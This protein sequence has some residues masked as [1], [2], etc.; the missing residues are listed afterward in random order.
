M[1]DLKKIEKQ[2]AKQQELLQESLT[3]VH[4]KLDRL[5]KQ[6]KESLDKTEKILNAI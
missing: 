6:A 2:L 3:N 4:K 1:S 5:E